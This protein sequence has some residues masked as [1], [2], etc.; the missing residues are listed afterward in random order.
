MKNRSQFFVYSFAGLA[1]CAV[2][3]VTLT[4]CKTTKT[5]PAAADRGGPPATRSTILAPGDVVRLTFPGAPENNQSQKIRPD[6]KISLPMVGEVVAAGRRPADLQSE[7]TALYKGQL[8]NNEVVVTLE[9]G[10]VA[11]YISGAIRKPGKMVFDRPTNLLEVIAEAG[12]LTPQANTRSIR[13][14]RVV[15]GEHRSQIIDLKPAL[16]GAPARAFYVR[17]NDIIQIDEKFLN[18]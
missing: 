6:G 8:V 9:S 18:F 12:G 16:S 17:P 11:V 1:L 2:M 13:I 10:A 3:M 15:N 5:S 14:I 7:L 4:G